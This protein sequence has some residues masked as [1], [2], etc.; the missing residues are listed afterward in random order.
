[1]LPCNLLKTDP[2][3]FVIDTLANRKIPQT[4]SDELKIPGYSDYLHPYDE[5]HL[6]GIGKEAVE[7]EQGVFC[8]VYLVFEAV[9]LWCKQRK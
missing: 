5:T 8:M 7:A 3:N 2:L 6:I 4:P 1:M 9:P